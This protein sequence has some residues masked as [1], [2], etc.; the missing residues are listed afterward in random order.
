MKTNRS[1]RMVR[2]LVLTLASAFIFA[3]VANAQVYKGNFTLPFDAQWG[4]ATLPAG[5]YSF[6]LDSVNGPCII[7]VEQGKRSVAMVMA[8]SNDVSKPSNHSALIVTRSG[9]RARIRALHLAELGTDLYYGAPKAE[10]W[11]MAS[12][13]ALIQ[14]IPVS[15]SGK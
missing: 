3:G 12:A 13:P 6:V 10:A 4:R 1:T 7:R 15:T 2:N 9:G 14:R 8:Q 5:D 11:E